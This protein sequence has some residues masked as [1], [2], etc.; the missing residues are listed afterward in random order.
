MHDAP[1]F[2]QWVAAERDSLRGL[3]LAGLH[4]LAAWYAVAGNLTQSHRSHVAICWY[5]SRGVK[6]HTATS[7]GCWRVTGNAA[8]H[9][10]SMRSV[11]EH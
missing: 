2:E 5:W 8:Q 10:H 9:L 11:G 4:R 1:D 3:A 7:C 6:R